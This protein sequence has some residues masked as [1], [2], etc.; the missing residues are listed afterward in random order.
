MVFRRIAILLCAA[1]LVGLVGGASQAQAPGPLAIDDA[2]A[3]VVYSSLLSN[4]WI[5]RVAKA[6]NLV[7]QEETA[8]RWTCMPSGP[9]LE[10]DWKPVLDSYRAAN[11]TTRAIRP[12]QQ[13]GLPY[14]VVPSRLIASAFDKPVQDGV[15]DGWQRYYRRYPGSGGYLQLSAVGF[16]PTKTRA[17]VYMAH[18]CGGLCG[19]GMHYLLERVE[20]VWREAK[21]PG[22]TQC[23]WAS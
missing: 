17:M 3:Y 16:N 13:I 4:E 19:E 1:I 18:S 7:I 14:Q 8:T 11:G 2:E 5:V 21:I 12:G 20:G 10:T 15:N 22:I 6:T 9:P 23:T